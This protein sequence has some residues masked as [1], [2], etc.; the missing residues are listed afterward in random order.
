MRVKRAW[1]DEVFVIDGNSIGV[2]WKARGCHKIKIDNVG[3]FYG[4]TGGAIVEINNC[5]QPLTIRF[6]GISG[7]R[8]TKIIHFNAAKIN[9]LNSF[10]AEGNL[11][12]LFNTVSANFDLTVADDE[13]FDLFC[14]QVLPFNETILKI[15]I[16][17]IQLSLAPFE[18]AKLNP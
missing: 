14:S 6:Y 16:G 7:R 10:E 2:S 5:S 17:E 11:P 12:K 3:V 1:C 8:I 15:E 9:L 18:A 13:F 4:A